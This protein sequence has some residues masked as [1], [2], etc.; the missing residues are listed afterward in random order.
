MLAGKFGLRTNLK[1]L[2]LVYDSTKN[3]FLKNVEGLELNVCSARP[4]FKTSD[5][6]LVVW[7]EGKSVNLNETLF[8]T[9]DRGLKDRLR[10]KGAKLIMNSG[11]WFKIARNL[12]G[13]KDF[14]ELVEKNSMD[15]K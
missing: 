8:V 7:S 10:E 5:D 12:I 15:S 2:T 9:S 13:D 6:A 1:H 3:V 14:N 4:D 11:R